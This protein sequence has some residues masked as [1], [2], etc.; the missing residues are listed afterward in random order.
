MTFFKRTFPETPECHV[1][2]CAYRLKSAFRETPECHLQKSA[3]RLKRAFRETPE[4]H[5]EKLPGK[6]LGSDLGS[7]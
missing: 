4:C 7:S 5:L 6:P 2:K 3:Y 1:D